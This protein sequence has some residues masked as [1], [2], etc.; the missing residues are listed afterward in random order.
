MPFG[1]AGTMYF[2]AQ[3]MEGHTRVSNLAMAGYSVGCSPVD[4]RTSDKE[5]SAPTRQPVLTL[6]MR[7]PVNYARLGLAGCGIGIALFARLALVVLLVRVWQ[8][9][10]ARR[11]R[12]ES[13]DAPTPPE[14][15]RVMEIPRH[16]RRSTGRVR[17]RST[18]TQHAGAGGR[19]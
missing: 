11:R 6:Y 1:L 5:E 12:L 18:V 8:I 10:C 16:R 9:V 4:G 2:I 3:A 13:C 15:S 17:W 19:C 7:C 14:Q